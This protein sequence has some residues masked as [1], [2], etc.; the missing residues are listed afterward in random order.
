MSYTK[1][2]EMLR[3]TRR[4]DLTGKTVVRA[5]FHG[6]RFE[7]IVNPELALKY[8]MGLLD[9]SV[10]I[11]EILEVDEIFQNASK[12]ERAPDEI[13]EHSFQTKDFNE[14][15]EKILTKG[16]LNLTTEQRQD[17]FE[18]K[19]KQIINILAKT[20]VNPKTRTPHPPTRIENAMKEAKVMIDPT[21]SAED[22]LKQIEA[23]INSMTLEERR[24][25]KVLN[26]SRRRRIASGS[27][28]D[29]QV[30]NQVMK[31]FRETQRLIKTIQKSGGRGLGRLMG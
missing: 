24:H 17:F 25:P 27:G 5:K 23:V 14:I 19:R 13:L 12:G 2:N 18:K 20:C 8:K 3:D 1:E 16:D 30:V 29:V 26:A 7:L 22:Q 10:T 15:V 31:R 4:F 28:L 11:E 9:E 21:K 6:N